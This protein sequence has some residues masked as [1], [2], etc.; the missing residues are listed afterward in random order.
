MSN[1]CTQN[2]IKIVITHSLWDYKINN[3]PKNEYPYIN[4]MNF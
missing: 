2:T 1:Q 4:A 3:T